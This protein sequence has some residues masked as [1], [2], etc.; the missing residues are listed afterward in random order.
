L[1]NR[2]R[3]TTHRAIL[4]AMD[5]EIAGMASGLP[6]GA[7][8]ALDRARAGLRDADAAIAAALRQ[9]VDVIV[10]DLVPTVVTERP[11]P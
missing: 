9:P 8:A 7:T 6:S 11:R 5:A 3:L 10:V 1:S 4:A 2:N